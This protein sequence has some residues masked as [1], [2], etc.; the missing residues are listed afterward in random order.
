MAKWNTL[1]AFHSSKLNSGTFPAANGPAFSERAT[2][3]GIPK[4]CKNWYRE[5]PSHLI[6]R[7]KFPEF[8]VEWLAFRK[9]NNSRI[10]RKLSH[11]TVLP[12]SP[13]GKVLEF[14]VKW[15]G[16]VVSMEHCK[17]T[18]SSNGGVFVIRKS[19]VQIFLPVTILVPIALFASSS[20]RALGTRNKGPWEHRIFELIWI[21]LIGCLKTKES[22]TESQNVR[23]D[24]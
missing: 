24:C 11:E 22:W 21:F 20:R 7:P 12:F 4:F 23:A 17:V 2:S 16:P 9:F 1:G 18:E 13:V 5:F 14:L 19:R 3:L 6:F 10:C 15:K 8:S